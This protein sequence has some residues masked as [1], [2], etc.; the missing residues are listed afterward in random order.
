MI[1]KYERVEVNDI[2]NYHFAIIYAPADPPLLPSLHLS[3]FFALL[4]LIFRPSSK[5]SS[6]IFIFFFPSF[7][8]CFQFR[9]LNPYSCAVS[10]FYVSSFSFLSFVFF[11]I[12]L[13]VPLSPSSLLLLIVLLLVPPLFHSFCT[14][15]QFWHPSPFVVLCVC[16][17]FF[18]LLLHLHLFPLSIFCLFNN[19]HVSAF[20]LL[21]ALLPDSGS[22]PSLAVLRDRTHGTRH[23]GRT[24]KDE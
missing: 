3:L 19:A 7:Y 9:L 11:S 2:I 18:P 20:L 6:S 13:P 5:V 1:S 17:C 23:T 4:M 16:V 22:W 21:V 12:S 10:C 24:P 14:C 8:R 15:S